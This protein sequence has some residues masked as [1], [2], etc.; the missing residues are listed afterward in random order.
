L[1]FPGQLLP[2]SHFARRVAVRY[3]VLGRL[4]VRVDDRWIS[5]PSTKWR[6]LLSVLLC[7]ANQVV[8]S[9]R[10][11]AELWED[12]LPQS[13]RKLLQGYVS[14][15]RRALGDGADPA[16]TT[17]KWGYQV[18]G[19][20]LHVANGQ[21][22]AQQF[23]RLFAE[24]RAALADGALPSALARL[25]EALRL[26]R[27]K[28]FMDL[29]PTPTVAAETV[30]LERI[31][32]QAMEA[33]IDT[34]MR[35]HDDYTALAELE[36]LVVEY[37]LQEQLNGQLMRALYRAGRQADALMVYRRLRKLLVDELGV[38]PGS[39]IQQLHQ[40]ILNADTALLSERSISEKQVTAAPARIAPLLVAKPSGTLTGRE[41]ELSALAG[42]LGPDGQRPAGAVVI[43]GIP[44]VGKSALA[45]EAAHR[46]A[47]R[48]PDGQI[49]L[50]LQGSTLG[51]SSL[52]A[53]EALQRL[54]RLLDPA[55]T[56]PLD[57]DE[58]SARLR[59]RLGH[60]RLILILDNVDDAERVSPILSARGGC[61]VLVTSRGVL[62]TLNGVSYIHLDVLGDDEAVAVLGQ[63]VGP[64][65]VAAEPD[66]SL[67]IA[68]LCG[69]LPLAL[70]IAG[71]RLVARPGW[72]LRVFAQRLGDSRT[73]LDQ[74][75]VGGLAVRAAFEVSYQALDSSDDPIDQ[76]A[77]SAFRAMGLLDE[78]SLGVP[79]I[80]T[81]LAE[82][83]KAVEA[84]L[85]RL[86]DVR[87]AE[88]AG[89]GRY[90][91]RGLPRLFAWE[92]TGSQRPLKI[93]ELNDGRTTVDLIRA[94]RASRDNRPGRPAG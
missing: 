93:S 69:G 72:S 49:Y 32:L 70:R 86:V 91:L 79:V 19:Y 13:S 48:F 33:R 6:L 75:Q 53:S 37:P 22:D 71:A 55:E 36:G 21:T 27:G 24:G 35:C 7:E 38:E 74:L 62:A 46:L 20:Q 77:T 81:L 43:D 83:P 58:S 80:A 26:W 61:A 52:T 65:R 23:E 45:I 17:H 73:R 57:P 59:S 3:R 40:Q 30:R 88:E 89:P 12:Q 92:K 5:L 14:H 8:P 11:I 56:A 67:Q 2:I 25:D 1:A 51:V 90:R 47:P 64:G 9:E 4:E 87:L 85:E 34:H 94:A 78:P 68:R 28:P 31:R 15:L 39:P 16:L 60:Q 50:D 76:L 63:L 42:M 10:L 66:A 54:L 41:R 84:S 18:H 29:P 82:R 44:G